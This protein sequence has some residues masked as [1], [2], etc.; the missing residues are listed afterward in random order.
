MVGPE[1]RLDLALPAGDVDYPLLRELASL[2]PTGN[3][4]PA[5]LVGVLGTTVSRVRAAKGGHTQLT[6]RRERD[7]VDAI[8]FDR[9]DLAD[10]V[11][12]GDR[13]DVVATLASRTFGGF[14]SLQLEILDV[15]TSGSHDEAAAILGLALAG[16]AR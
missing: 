5:P 12:E 1:L 9:A 13:I 7:V 14:E 4:N 8:A 11:A 6:L 3:G 10:T 16:A 15:A 2:E